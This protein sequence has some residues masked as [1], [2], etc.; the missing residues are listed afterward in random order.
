MPLDEYMALCLG[1]PEHGYY[2]TRDPL[3]AAGDFTTAPEISQMFGE[4]VG[5]WLAEVWR[6]QGAPARFV[7]AELGPGRGT[8]MRDALRVASRL[9]GFAEAAELWLVE[10]SPALRA[11]Q[12]ETLAGHGPN[13]AARV[14]ELPAG[15]LYLVANEF[16]DALPARQ[17]RRADMAWLERLVERAGPGLAFRWGPPR[18]E[19]EL[20]RRFPLA[21][22]GA[23]VECCPAA[24]AIAGAVGA[25]IASAGG[26]ALV[27]DYG[28]WDGTGD[29][30][31]ALRA[32]DSVDP[33]AEPGAADL[34]THV[35]F[36][37]LAEAAGPVAVAGPV[38][39]GVFLERLGITA[40]ANA[41]ARGRDAGGVA[42][43]AAAHRRLTHPDEMGNLFRVLG[44]APSNSAPLP[45]LDPAEPRPGMDR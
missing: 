42:A 38:A 36:R 13:W 16:F 34:T 10:T 21:P 20:A 3:G 2:A 15:P 45:G 9:P 40:R 29:T 35:R 44:F 6:G 18:A 39:Q 27:I 12:A 43:I 1:H 26:A 5:A 17:F 24:E 25:R 23:V 8:L 32:H 41:L 11:R 31:Q 33:L 22:D 30:L 7:L 19:P 14:E 4:L 37:A 28:A